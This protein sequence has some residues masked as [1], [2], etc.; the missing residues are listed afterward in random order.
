MTRSA[1]PHARASKRLAIAPTIVV[2]ALLGACG[3]S[4]SP[5]V[6]A[7]AP[8]PGAS[9]TPAPARPAPPGPTTSS[10]T[11]AGNGR[12]EAPPTPGCAPTPSF[13][14][15][16][17]RVVALDDAAA[18]IL[19][20][21]GLGDRIVGT[22]GTD[23]AADFTGDLRNRLDS[24]KVLGERAA[25]RE[26]VV[27]ATPDVVIGVS[28][29]E[30]GSFDGTATT[31]QLDQAG[32]KSLVACPPS[33]AAS[34]LDDTYA[35]VSALATA[36]GVPAAGETL[37]ADLR[38]QV[39]AAR[40]PYAGRPAVRV[41]AV[42]NSPTSGQGINTRG[43]KSLATAIIGAAGGTNIA[44]TVTASFAQLSGE[45]VVADDPQAIL[46]VTGLGPAGADALVK[47]IESSPT[48]QQTTAVKEH[49]VVVV[50][51]TTLLTASLLNAAA[52]QTVAA[53]IH[54]PAR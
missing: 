25:T 22:S 2:A 47:A 40:A 52:V 28:P 37:N 16:P 26:L 9:G 13:A 5:T 42:T 14:A 7:E 36:F 48:L 4:S 39:D 54:Q 8:V 35:Y 12:P 1:A 50:P 49:R 38:Q 17:R 18:A 32:I 10:T 51:Q 15:P 27:A 31:G 20:K 30:L 24:L 41:L 21:L 53:G 11:A 45:T 6:T 46:A 44:A 34:T 33:G 43:A 19:I 23:F 3:G 29:L